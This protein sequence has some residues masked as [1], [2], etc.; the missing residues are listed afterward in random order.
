MICGNTHAEID[1][2]TAQYK[3]ERSAEH[4]AATMIM[5][6]K[7]HKFV[8]DLLANKYHTIGKN[9]YTLRDAIECIQD[10]NFWNYA[11]CTSDEPI[12]ELINN[13]GMVEAL[14]EHGALP[15]FHS[16]ILSAVES[17]ADTVIGDIDD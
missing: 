12:S 10:D 16:V 17:L 2:D 13:D 8:S 7:R 3:F 5:K 11:P 15:K 9:T 14:Y 4:L 6:D 1:N